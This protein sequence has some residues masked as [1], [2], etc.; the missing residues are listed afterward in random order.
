MNAT[1]HTNAVNVIEPRSTAVVATRGDVA[2]GEMTP[3]EVNAWLARR[4]ELYVEG[5]G[6]GVGEGAYA[7]AQLSAANI[8][9]L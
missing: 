2:G 3:A 5:E 7:V 9:C 6:N 4:K 1:D 8:K